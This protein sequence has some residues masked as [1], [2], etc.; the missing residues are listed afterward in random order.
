MKEIQGFPS[1]AKWCMPLLAGTF[2]IVTADISHP[3][4]T[5]AVDMGYFGMLTL[6]KVAGQCLKKKTP[7]TQPQIQ[8]PT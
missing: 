3:V 7:K 2:S 6:G 4:S 8:Q 1:H 5:L